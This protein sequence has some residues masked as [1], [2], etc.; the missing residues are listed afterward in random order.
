LINKYYC[1]PIIIIVY[2]EL[3]LFVVVSIISI[4]FKI[5]LSNSFNWDRILFSLTSFL[6]NDLA[7]FF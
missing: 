5:S 1:I 7:D 6:S 4:L 3:F 2:T